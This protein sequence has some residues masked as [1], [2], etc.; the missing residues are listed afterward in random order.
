MPFV[1]AVSNIDAAR[2]QISLSPV[3][4]NLFSGTQLSITEDLASLL[5]EED[6]FVLVLDN[7]PG[8]GRLCVYEYVIV[9]SW[10][11]GVYG[12]YTSLPCRRF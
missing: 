12:K 10:F 3:R 9:R 6:D 8:E 2:G 11:R 7:T 1:V 4:C 5:T